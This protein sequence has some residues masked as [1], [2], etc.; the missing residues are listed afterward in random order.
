MR[1]LKGELESRLV[2]RKC[3]RKSL[4]KNK[5]FRIEQR[6]GDLKPI[7]CVMEQMN[8]NGMTKID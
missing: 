5:C 2:N 3:Q 8:Q 6:V 7:E 1:G 4:R